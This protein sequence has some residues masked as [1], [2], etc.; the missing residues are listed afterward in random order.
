MLS[1]AKSGQVMIEDTPKVSMLGYSS[2]GGLR[3][4]FK[5]TDRALRNCHQFIISM[6]GI[7]VLDVGSEKKLYRLSQSCYGLFIP[8]LI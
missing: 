3:Y 6:S 2:E 7:V 5:F 4:H 8:R 1:I